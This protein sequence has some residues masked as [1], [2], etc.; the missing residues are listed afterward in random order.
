MPWGCIAFNSSNNVPNPYVSLHKWPS[1]KSQAEALR[2]F[3]S[4]IGMAW[5]PTSKIQLCF[6]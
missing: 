6:K 1:G 3:V 2:R 5:K 4:N